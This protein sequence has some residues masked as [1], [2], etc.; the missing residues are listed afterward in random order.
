[1]GPLRLDSVSKLSVNPISDFFRLSLDIGLKNEDFES[2]DADMLELF[3]VGTGA[4][5]E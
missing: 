2:L 1:M 5:V 3:P 4:D